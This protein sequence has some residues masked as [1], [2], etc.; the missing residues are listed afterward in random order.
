LID[1]PL[2]RRDFREEIARFVEWF[3]GFRP[4]TFLNGRTPNEVY[5]RRHPACRYPRLEPREHW[6][7]VPIRGKP[8]AKSELHL[9]VHA[10]RKHLPVVTLERAA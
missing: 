4:H 7:R 8:G 10:G 5:E 1:V 9:D 3:N 2:R 6:P